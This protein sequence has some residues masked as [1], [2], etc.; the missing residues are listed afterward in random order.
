VDGLQSFMTL[1]EAAQTIMFQVGPEV[2]GNYTISL[3]IT[4]SEGMTASA[5]VSFQINIVEIADDETIIT[6]NPSVIINTD[7]NKT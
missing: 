5:Q 4:D 2:I 3:V 7:K 1:D 6:F